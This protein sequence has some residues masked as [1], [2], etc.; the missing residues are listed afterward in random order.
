MK[1]KHSVQPKV[2]LITG[3]AHRVGAAIVELLHTNG[4]NIALHYR[5][6]FTVA[7]ATQERLNCLRPNSVILL[8]ADLSD[9]QA[10]PDIVNQAAAEWGHLDLLVNN[11]SSFYPSP[12]G[13]VDELQWD[14]LLASNLK[15]P[16]FLAQAAQKFLANKHGS[17]INIV[18]IHADRPL[19][20]HT[21]YC[22]AKAGLVMLTKSLAREFG[23]DIRVNA[24]A[25]GAI[26]W[27][28]DITEDLKSEIVSRTALKRK[29]EPLDIAKAVL[30][31]VENAD[32][33]TGQVLTIDG[34]RSLNS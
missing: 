7:K 23:D 15:A 2:A 8:K 20:N 5:N 10:L 6:S 1:D 14:D 29:G 33:M 19:K 34:G 13:S 3:A 17:I 18:D 27:P 9:I 26:M 28:L 16:F 31:L 32:Y 22:V 11:A 21:V 4:M 24:I 30:Y 25:P 12:I